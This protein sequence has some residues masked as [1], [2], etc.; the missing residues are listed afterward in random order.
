M[1]K[2]GNRTDPGAC[3]RY[4]TDF[5]SGAAGQRGGSVT[6]GRLARPGPTAA[7]VGTLFRE[8]H[9]DLVRLA[10]LMVGGLPT[11]EDVVQ[12]VYASLHRRW[13]QI[14]VPDEVLPYV[15]AA[16]LNRCRSVLRR[17]AAARRAAAR[18]AG[19]AHRDEADA[20]SAESE[21]ILSED[22]R[23][24]LVALARLPR[25]RR[26]AVAGLPGPVV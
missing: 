12:D 5:G 11:A 20:R 16:V 23:Q 8:H 2:P 7:T 22:R 1:T 19:A 26:E 25:R 3:N 6:D 9:G 24:V 15:R 17:R 21:V 14:A 4:G 18:R 13:S 10:V